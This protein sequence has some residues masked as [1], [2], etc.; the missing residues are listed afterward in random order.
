MTGFGR[1]NCSPVVGAIFAAA[2]RARLLAASL[3]HTVGAHARIAL[4]ASGVPVAAG[5]RR[6]R[7]G[8]L[9]HRPV[10]ALTHGGVHHEPPPRSAESALRMSWSGSGFGSRSRAR[11]S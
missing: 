6:V 4:V 2:L 7:C 9:M 5:D 11:E 8:G 10:G 1:G 3:A